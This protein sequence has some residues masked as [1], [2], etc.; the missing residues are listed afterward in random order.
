M[1]EFSLVAALMEQIE[2]VAEDHQFSQVTQVHVQIG[3]LRQVVP[4]MMQTA[5]KATSENTIAEGSTLAL[6]ETQIVA[7]C[8]DCGEKF[9]PTI[10]DFQCP[11]CAS[12]RVKILEGQDFT[13]MSLNGI[14]KGT[15]DL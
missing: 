10:H 2:L 8:L 1:H 6:T 9:A 7:E 14:Q 13:L 4:E 3:A 15:A 12:T 5:Y 11:A